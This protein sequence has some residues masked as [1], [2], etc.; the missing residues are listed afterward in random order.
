V[1][2]GA[3]AFFGCS[4]SLRTPAIITPRVGLSSISVY[5]DVYPEAAAYPADVPAQPQSTPYTMQTGQRYVA[6]STSVK[7]DYYYDATINYSLPD[8]HIIVVGNQRY[9]EI[10]FNHHVGF[11]KVED[12]RL[13]P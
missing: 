7:S 11:V 9:Y 3:S 2:G 6:N 5:T 4:C 13:Q 12:V 10:T 1:D 8:D